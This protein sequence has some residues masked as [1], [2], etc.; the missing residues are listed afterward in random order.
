MAL[1]NR[2]L[3]NLVLV[4]AAVIVIAVVVNGFAAMPGLRVTADATKTRAYSL[5]AQTQAMLDDLA[6]EWTIAVVMSPDNVDMAVR[7][8]VDEVLDRFAE[9]PHISVLRLDPSDPATLDQ[10]ESLLSGLRASYREAIAEYEQ[11][12]TEGRRAVASFRLL[13][14]QQ[15]GRLS[16]LLQGI[17]P[18]HPDRE[19]AAQLLQILALRLEQTDQVDTELDRALR[20]DETRPLAD[21]DAARSVLAAALGGWAEEQ[22]RIARMLRGW[23]E[24]EADPALLQFAADVHEAYDEQAHALALVADPLRYL[25]DLELG[26]IGR[27]LEHGEAGIV[28]GPRGAAVIP[29]AGLFPSL[30][31]RTEA[32][33]IAYDQRFRGEQIF[34]ATIR[35]LLVEQMPMVVFLHAQEDSLLVRR[36]RNVDL[37]GAASMLGASRFEVK[38]WI[39]GSSD[40]PTPAPGR[41]VVWIVIPPPSRKGLEPAAA[42]LQ[43]VDAARTLLADGESVLLSVYPSVLSRF[44]LSD[45]WQRVADRFGISVETGAV[46]FEE[47][48]VSRDESSRRRVDWLREFPADHPIARAVHG[49]RTYLALPVAIL[50]AEPPPGTLIEVIARI[51][52]SPDRWMEADWSVDSRVVAE[53]ERGP[54]ITEP[55]TVMVAVET[56][57]PLRRGS[58]QRAIVI[59]SGGWMLSYVA[60]VAMPIGGERVVLANPGNYELLLSSVAWLAGMDDLIAPSPVSRQVARLDGITAAVRRRWQWIALLLAPGACVVLGVVVWMVRRV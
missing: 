4:L 11:A 57:H 15:T 7:R 43:L 45:P 24:T 56:R 33:S 37:V 59:G 42:E 41:P 39:V 58:P 40:P 44:G 2:D 22:L 32:D 26:R 52:A 28:T 3:L 60:D 53:M 5:S 34:A 55:V 36:D 13:L 46:V 1:I 25:P 54:A 30:A 19:S 49:R 27:A 8:Q 31:V 38:E 23:L 16:L 10:Y 35:S 47:L 18:D 12:L 6:G 9:S 48:Q 14:Q 21:Y 20:V 51:E 50:V 29:S 17:A